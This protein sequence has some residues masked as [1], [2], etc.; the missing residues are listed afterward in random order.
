MDKKN[1]KVI[2]VIALAAL[3][4]VAATLAAFTAST[5]TFE[6]VSTNAI[7]IDIVTN[8]KVGSASASGSAARVAAGARV[9]ESVAVINTTEVPVYVR[10]TANKYW[11]NKDGS[12]NFDLKND[13]IKFISTSKDW[14]VQTD[15]RNEEIV[16]FYYTKPLDGNLTTSNLV[17]GY[18]MVDSADQENSNKYAGQTAQVD[19]KANGIQINNAAKAMKAEWGVNAVMNSDGTIT[20]ITRQGE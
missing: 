5:K 10:V 16:Y 3:M 19:Y 8:G 20:S 2:I 14:I 12:K 7:G 1:K 17:D 18:T 6:D 11:I 15:P 9:N 13:Q 4:L